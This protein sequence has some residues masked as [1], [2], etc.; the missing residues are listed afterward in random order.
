MIS[1]TLIAFSLL[2]S[3]S[4]TLALE[5]S[6]RQWSHLPTGLNF[7]GMGYAYVEADINFDPVL[8]LADVE[9]ESELWLGKYIHTFA[10]FDRSARIDITQGYQEAE[11]TG[12]LQDEPAKATRN[13]PT[14]TFVRF[15]SNLY[16]APALQ[17]KDFAAYRAANSNDT[18]VGFGL[19]L[20]LPTGDYHDKRLL[21]LGGNRYVLRPQLGISRQHGPW[22]LEATTEASLFFDNDEFFDGNKLEQDPLYIVH[23]HLI[24]T[25]RPGLWVSASAGYD[26]GGEST[27]NGQS[28][29][30]T[31]QNTGWSLRG[32]IPISRTLGINIA[33]V[34]TRTE[35]DTG[36]DIESLLASFAYMW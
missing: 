26:Y 28:K 30:D 9:M 8:E 21:N 25:F 16:G 23:A 5:L 18:I 2:L 1:R 33:Y 12:L 19:V 20:R 32:A 3:C 27:L 10:L 22:T 11:W 24:Y 35:E 13:G 31:K 6:P 34:S 29:D 17:G 7:G 4:Y 36:A 14:D 15:S